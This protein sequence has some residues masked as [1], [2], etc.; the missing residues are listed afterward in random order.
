MQGE[1]KKKTSRP[2]TTEHLWCRCRRWP[3]MFPIWWASRCRASRSPAFGDSLQRRHTG[4]LM[5]ATVK[6]H[7]GRWSPLRGSLAKKT[8]VFLRRKKERKIGY[9]FCCVRCNRNRPQLLHTPIEQQLLLV[10][11]Q[12]PQHV[13]HYELFSLKVYTTQFTNKTFIGF[14]PTRGSMTT[15]SARYKVAE[16]MRS[17]MDFIVHLLDPVRS[18]RIDKWCRR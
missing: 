18:W 9:S 17:L 6:C 2:K 8:V 11:E 13:T 3:T 16:E 12:L 5:H 14:L 1:R 4:L 10:V 7:R 15:L